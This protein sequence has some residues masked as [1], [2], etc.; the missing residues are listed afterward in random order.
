MNRLEADKA[1][2]EFRVATEIVAGMRR[3]FG[4]C[5]ELAGFVVHEADG[6][7]VPVERNGRE[8]RLYLA[9]IGFAPRLGAEQHDE[10]LCEIARVLAELVAERPEAYAMLRGRTFARELH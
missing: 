3:L 10:V 9:E 7:P 2:R 1:L 8:E 5:P 4:R 6:L